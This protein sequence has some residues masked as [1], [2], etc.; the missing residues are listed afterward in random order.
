LAQTPDDCLLIDVQT[1]RT[2]VGSD[3]AKI[4]NATSYKADTIYQKVED[5]GV[6]EHKAISST[7][8]APEIMEREISNNSAV[9]VP[10][11][12]Q[13]PSEYF[14]DVCKVQ[15]TGQRSHD[16]HMAG[17]PHQKALD[18]LNA[19]PP[20]PSAKA[21]Q[22]VPAV[23]QMGPASSFNNEATLD[24]QRRQMV[25]ELMFEFIESFNPIKGLRY[26]RGI[27]IFSPSDSEVV[28]GK[29]T[30]EEKVVEF[31]TVLQNKVNW[32]DYL[33]AILKKDGYNNL[34]IQFERANLTQ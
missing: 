29:L 20:T 18:R 5:M 26:L 21:N 32:F 23:S 13:K 34:L 6:T 19:I 24:A 3:I 8:S 14:C 16:D 27:R 30:R 33:V 17:R 22:A 10:T 1:F 15:S 2:Q 9:T 25:D 11:T 4:H 12:E 31:L 7:N 28:D